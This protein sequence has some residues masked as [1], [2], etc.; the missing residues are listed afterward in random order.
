M[1]RPNNSQQIK[2]TCRIVDF[3]VL[4]DHRVKLKEIEKKDKYM[5][6]AR[7]LKKVMELESDGDTNYNWRTRYNHQRIDT[8]IGGLRNKKASGDHRN[9]SII[10]NGHN[11]KK[12]PGDLRRLAVTQTPVRNHQLT[13]EWKILKRTKWLVLILLNFIWWLHL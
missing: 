3:A 2:I 1:T 11:T 10:E 6:L 13:L 5:D 4:A 9:Y 7:E 12:S 8:R